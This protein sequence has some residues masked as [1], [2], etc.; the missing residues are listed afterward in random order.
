MKISDF[1]PKML[2]GMLPWLP[3]TGGGAYAQSSGYDEPLYDQ[4]LVTDASQLYSPM[5]IKGNPPS[6][7]IDGNLYSYCH[8]FF[9]G[10]SGETIEPRP[11]K[12]NHYLRISYPDVRPPR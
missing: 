6:N 5:A 11:I 2:L 10:Y 9:N 8:T 3:L 7:L 4:P 12:E 1:I